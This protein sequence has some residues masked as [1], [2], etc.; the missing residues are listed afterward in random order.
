MVTK[1]RDNLGIL[2]ICVGYSITFKPTF[3][4]QTNRQWCFM[5]PSSGKRCRHSNNTI[6]RRMPDRAP[7]PP[8]F[9]VHGLTVQLNLFENESPAQ[10]DNP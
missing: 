6:F 5:A 4:I 7:P 9:D 1:L 8:G 3:G 2:L 10:V